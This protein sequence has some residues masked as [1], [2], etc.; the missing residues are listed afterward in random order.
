VRSSSTALR[1]DRKPAAR[2]SAAVWQDAALAAFAADG[3]GAVA[4]EPLARRLKVT[5]GS[6]YWHY[7]SRD[8]LLRAALRRWE[9]TST[10]AL[11]E[12]VTQV[13]DPQRRL[14]TLFSAVMPGG[15]PERA[16]ERAIA[17][18]AAH[19]VVAPILHRVSRRRIDYLAKCFRALGFGS[20]AARHRA[21]LTYAA[22]VGG[23]RLIR[24]APDRYPRGPAYLRYRAHVIETL[25]P[26][27]RARV[28]R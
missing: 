25:I 28:A 18:A 26:L 11:I 27:R 15:T 4:I 13:S 17:D 1:R 10:A 19:P 2:L 14:E 6:F 8:E 24:D 9:R 23:T 7:A 22:Y 3:L 16:L 20:E 12:S 5:K 21:V